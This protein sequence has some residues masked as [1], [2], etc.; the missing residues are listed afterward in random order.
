MALPLAVDLDGTLIE[1]DSS[2]MSYLWLVRNDPL[3]ALLL[4][5]LFFLRRARFTHAVARR[6]VPDATALSYDPAIVAY[7][8]EQRAVGREIVLATASNIAIASA[9]AEHLGCFHRVIASDERTYRGGRGKARALKEQFGERGFVYAG[10]AWKD[11][12]VWNDAAAAIICHAPRLL[13]AFA[14]KRYTIERVF[15]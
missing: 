13:L 6:F 14:R 9:V 7:I 8:R 1:G 3:T 4:L 11:L 5:P 2:R 10:N 15:R 12:W